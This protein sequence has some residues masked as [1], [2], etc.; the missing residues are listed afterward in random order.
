MPPDTMLNTRSPYFWLFCAAAAA[1]WLVMLLSSIDAESMN[2]AIYRTLYA[3]PRTGLATAAWVASVFGGWIFLS[4]STLAGAGFLAALR[5]RR[6]RRAALLLITVFGARFVIELQKVVFQHPRPSEGESL[7]SLSFPS[8]HAGNAMVVFLALALLVPLGQAA[9]RRS[10]LL[11]LTL[12]FVV[13][14]SRVV[15]GVH[16]PSDVVGGWAFGLL[17]VLFCIRL[18][19]VRPEAGASGGG[20]A[21]ST[22]VIFP[23]EGDEP[24]ENPRTDSARRNDDSDIIDNSEDAPSFA[25]TSGGNLQRDVAT[26]AEEEH[27]LTGGPGTTRVT[28]EDKPPDGDVPTLPN[29]DG[30]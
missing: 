8:A 27:G 3:R 5:P 22:S 25:G 17:W 1:L 23:G 26:Q 13:G 10:V 19:S 18:A 9:R 14:L 28:G 15:L 21:S 12:A 24:M 11:A 6:P 4:L 29:R 20:N 16:W 7:A 30:D 2:E